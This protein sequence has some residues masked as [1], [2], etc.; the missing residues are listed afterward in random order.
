[1][2][3][4]RIFVAV[5]LAALFAVGWWSGRD[6]GRG[7]LYS[8]L[9]TFI[10][11]LHKVQENYVTPVDPP[12][13]VRGAIQ[14]MLQT[15]DPYSQYLDPKEYASLKDVTRGS[16]T[17]VGI[18]VGLR[19]R[20]PTVIAPLEGGPAWEAGLQTGDVIVRVDGR[21]TADFSLDD[22]SNALRGT[23]GSHVKVAIAR[24][25]DSDEREF[26]LV[27]REINVASIPYAFV[28]AGGVGYLRLARFSEDAD[29]R[30]AKALTSLRGAGATSLVLDL[31]S[32]PGGLLDQAVDVAGGFLPRGSAVVSTRGRGTTVGQSY[33]A[34]NGRPETAWPMAVLVDEG[35]A[36]ASEIVAGALQDLDRALVV[37]E[38]SFG[39]GSV[40]NLFPLPGEAGAVKLTTALYYTPSGRSIHR[41]GRVAGAD[42]L[43]DDDDDDDEADSAAVRVPATRDSAPAALFHTA[44]GRTVRGGG[45]ITPDVVVKSDTLGPLAMALERRGLALRFARRWDTAHPAPDPLP[46]EATLWPEL[47]RFLESEGMRPPADSLMLERQRLGELARREIARRRGGDAAAAR[48]ALEHDEVFQRAAAILRRAHVAGDVFALSRDGATT[49]DAATRPAPRREAAKRP[50]PKPPARRTHPNL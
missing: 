12:R 19:D 15:L 26:D 37:G 2:I 31:R 5:L 47:T 27:R 13:M 23:S 46:A 39:K 18:E 42:P 4:R 40:Q 21:S 22:V 14:G 30:L 48:V 28:T 45:G 1:M 17:G 34:H 3:Q 36:S 33:T 38:T 6:G 44:A 11:V 8:N 25:G 10:E 20:F 24:E 49:A 29:G 9:D 16:F 43:A 32:D 35:T 50:V 41:G 7:E